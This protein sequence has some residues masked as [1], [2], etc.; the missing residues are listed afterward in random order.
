MKKKIADIYLGEDKLQPIVFENP[1]D[2]EILDEDSRTD[3]SEIIKE[4]LR[5]EKRI[6]ELLGDIMRRKR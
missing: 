4:I 5:S 3:D 6:L 1:T 2:A